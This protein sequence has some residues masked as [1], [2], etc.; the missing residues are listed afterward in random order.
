MKNNLI[1]KNC[2]VLR[3]QD[4]KVIVDVAQDIFIQGNQIQ[5]IKPTG[6]TYPEGKIFDA[7]GMLAT[8]GFI[9]T[10][11]HVPMVLFRGLAEDVTTAAWFNDYIFPIESNLTPEDVYWGAMLGIAEMIENGVTSVADHYFYMDD[12]ARAIE[13]SGM[14][15]NLVWAVFGHEGEEKL[16]QTA[17]FIQRWQGKADGRITTWLG[18][19]A[20]YTTGPDFLKLSVKKAREL[21]VGIHTHV[22]ESSDQVAMSLDEFNMTPVR[23]LEDCGVLD[24]PTILA[25]CAYPT[26]EDIQILKKYP[27]G[28]GHAPKTFMKGG[29]GIVTLSHFRD[30]GI[31]VG[32]ATDGAASNNTMDIL[33]AMRLSALSQKHK[34]QDSTA[35]PLYDVLDTAFNGSARVL[36]MGDKLGALAAGKLADLILIRQDGLNV[37]PR[38][39]PAANLVYSSRSTDIDTVICNGKILMKNRELLTVDKA[40]IKK[41]VVQRLDRLNK[42]IP[43]K[44]VA[45][46]PTRE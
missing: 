31:P 39:N 3:L 25:H 2:D 37:L 43:G 24:L 12:V 13:D 36:K 1:I 33:E 4:G 35:F 34:A 6:I 16:D 29:K 21:N 19:H 32:L 27:T 45:T 22:S 11:A 40:Q 38:Y 9:N 28:V 17:E 23:L 10:H 5:S 44:R 7:S 41:E 42:I 15:A 30:N 46:Y 20:P 26:D 8:P 14:R 18:P